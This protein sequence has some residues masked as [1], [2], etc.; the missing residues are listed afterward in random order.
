MKA[1]GF[2]KNKKGLEFHWSLYEWALPLSVEVTEH[3]VFVRLLCASLIIP[4]K[5]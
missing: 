5:R 1:I 2:I 3:L 4:K